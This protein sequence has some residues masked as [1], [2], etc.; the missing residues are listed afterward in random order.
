MSSNINKGLKA[1]S[2]LAHHRAVRAGEGA[3]DLSRQKQAAWEIAVGERSPAAHPPGR[4]MHRGCLPD[5]DMSL[6]MPF[7]TKP[8]RVRMIAG[9]IRNAFRDPAKEERR[10]LAV[11]NL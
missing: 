10:H 3:S 7:P 9:W 2:V 4:R 8:S 5:V 6:A 1:P 11:R